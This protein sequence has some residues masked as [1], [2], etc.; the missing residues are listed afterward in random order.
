VRMAL[1]ATE[2]D[3]TRMVQTSALALVC[4][5]LAVGAPLAFWS[6]RLA[7]DLVD[8]LLVNAAFPVG[9]AAAVTIAVGLLAAY[10]PARRAARVHPMEA[11]RHS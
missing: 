11:L 9:V 6:Q 7:A 10:V 1:G 4:A 5:G 8:D 2:R 3:V